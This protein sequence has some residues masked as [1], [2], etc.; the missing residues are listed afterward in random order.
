M[1]ALLFSKVRVLAEAYF[2]LRASV[3]LRI[4]D[5]LGDTPLAE[6]AKT[7]LRS[8]ADQA[9]ALPAARGHI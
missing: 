4:L 1:P 2:R 3:L 9:R 6:Q 8:H 7:A 5:K